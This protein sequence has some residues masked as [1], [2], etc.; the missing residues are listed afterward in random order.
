MSQIATG[1]RP[2]CNLPILR[3]SMTLPISKSKSTVDRWTYFLWELVVEKGGVLRVH[4]MLFVLDKTQLHAC[5]S[6][7]VCVSEM[8]WGCAVLG[9]DIGICRLRSGE[10]WN[11]LKLE[12]E[13]WSKLKQLKIIAPT[14]F[15][16]EIKV[17]AVLGTEIGIWTQSGVCWNSLKLESGGEA[18]E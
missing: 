14:P 1:L 10:C 3:V 7:Y 6:V 12:A 8:Q 18:L 5:V 4:T 2:W 15:F 17:R 16:L 13:L 11:S 9:V